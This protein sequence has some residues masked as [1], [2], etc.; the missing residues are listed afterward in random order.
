VS[1][2]ANYLQYE[3]EEID[4]KD[5]GTDFELS[6][7]YKMNRRVHFDTFVNRADRDV[8]G[9]QVFGDPSYGVTTIGVGVRLFP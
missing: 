8:S 1:A 6:A 2:S 4:R 9:V 7:T 3:F 5:V